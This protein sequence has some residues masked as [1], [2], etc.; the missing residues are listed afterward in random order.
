MMCDSHGPTGGNRFT[1][2][3]NP[4]QGGNITIRQVPGVPPKNS[5]VHTTHP[6][7]RLEVVPCLMSGYG[8]C[9]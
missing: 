7:F 3:H 5:P 6:I 8:L 2:L 1:R 9:A 4:N